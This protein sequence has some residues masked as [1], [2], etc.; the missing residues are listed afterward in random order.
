MES[1]RAVSR[2]SGPSFIIIAIKGRIYA[3]SRKVVRNKSSLARLSIIWGLK[4]HGVADIAVAINF[5]LHFYN[6]MRMFC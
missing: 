4:Q 3:I 6:S 2:L 1:E 5:T